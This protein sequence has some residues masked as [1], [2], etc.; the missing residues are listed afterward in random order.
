[1]VVQ[2]NGQY[3][4]HLRKSST[5]KEIA[6]DS[7]PKIIAESDHDEK[8]EQLRQMYQCIQKLEKPDQIIILMTLEGIPYNEI[9]EVVGISE[10]N[11][12]VRIHRIKKKLTQC[13]QNENI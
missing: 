7:F 13:V 11:L 8:E 10:D 1:L 6:T 5:K 2:N 12:R 4:L 3:L 9:A